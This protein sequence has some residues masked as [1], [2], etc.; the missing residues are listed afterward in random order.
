MAGRGINLKRHCPGSQQRPGETGS[1]V[2]SNGSKVWHW[3]RC[4]VCGQR[5]GHQTMVPVHNRRKPT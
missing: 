4:R 3:G 1:E 5:F 2:Y